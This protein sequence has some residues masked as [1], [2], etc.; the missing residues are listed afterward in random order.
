MAP[1]HGSDGEGRALAPL[2]PH[3]LPSPAM[4][5]TPFPVA[6]SLTGGGWRRSLIQKIR[7]IWWREKIY[8]C[9]DV[10]KDINREKLSLFPE[11]KSLTGKCGEDD[12]YD[13][14]K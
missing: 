9:K 6:G 14:L 5:P 12:N 3:L 2:P 10:I 8:G 1:W 7:T 11:E 4:D 13:R